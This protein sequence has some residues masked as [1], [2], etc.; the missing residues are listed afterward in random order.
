MFA[1]LS[2]RIGRTTRIVK[3]RSSS[4]DSGPFVRFRGI[5]DKPGLPTVSN[6]PPEAFIIERGIRVRAPASIC[7]MP[8][9]ENSISPGTITSRRKRFPAD[10]P[11]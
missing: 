10:I 8:T 2:S 11:R 3:P 9:S 4:A 7:P 1:T 6:Q 5:I